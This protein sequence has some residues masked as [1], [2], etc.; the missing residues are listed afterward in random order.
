MEATPRPYK[1]GME[2]VGD[3]LSDMESRWGVIV[4]VDL[5]IKEVRPFRGAMCLTIGVP[6]AEHQRELDN[7]PT[8]CIPLTKAMEADIVWA[9]WDGLYQWDRL[10]CAHLGVP[11]NV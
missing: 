9:I 5:R 1:I 11:S 2:S 7:P 3:Y 4:A 8:L 6:F 10:L